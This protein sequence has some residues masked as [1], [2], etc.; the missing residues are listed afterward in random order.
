[1][2]LRY[3]RKR[4]VQKRSRLR[5]DGEVKSCKELKNRPGPK[6]RRRLL[7]FNTG[8]AGK[9]SHMNVSVGELPEMKRLEA[10]IKKIHD[11]RKKK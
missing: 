6:M 3:N 10:K 9:E 5:R 4:T 2:D 8:P 1:M 11:K 7:G